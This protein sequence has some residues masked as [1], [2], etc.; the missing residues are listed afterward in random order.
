MFLGHDLVSRHCMVH[1]FLVCASG[2]QR[3]W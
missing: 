1:S 2:L 3:I